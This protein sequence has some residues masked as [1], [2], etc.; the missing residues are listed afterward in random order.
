MLLCRGGSARASYRTKKH[1]HYHLV[2]RAIWAQR[3]HVQKR[4]TIRRADRRPAPTQQRWR[5]CVVS[6]QPRLGCPGQYGESSEP[7][8]AV[9]DPCPSRM[10]GEQMLNCAKT[11][12][13]IRSTASAR[14]RSIF[15]EPGLFGISARRWWR[16]RF[17]NEPLLRRIQQH[18]D[19]PS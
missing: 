8:A 9:C 14:A 15:A 1:R 17:A 10:A 4:V 11:R 18:G 7:W 13:L 5:C 3:P 12:Q 2:R 16:Y 19:E 6:V